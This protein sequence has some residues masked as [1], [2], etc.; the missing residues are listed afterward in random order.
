VP[1]PPALKEVLAWKAESCG[2]YRWMQ[3]YI[4]YFLRSISGNA[5]IRIEDKDPGVR[6]LIN[7][8]LLLRAETP[9][10]FDEHIATE[11]G[12]NLNRLV[13]APGIDDDDLPGK[14]NIFQTGGQILRLI[15]RND[16]HRQGYFIF[17]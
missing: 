9:P 5:F 10:R 14:G 7:G 16:G 3:D 15:L 8:I 11:V 17:Y 1:D 2:G 12:C 13:C 6:A 4:F